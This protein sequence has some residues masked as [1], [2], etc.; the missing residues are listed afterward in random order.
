MIVSSKPEWGVSMPREWNS[1]MLFGNGKKC[2]DPAA[3]SSVWSSTAARNH[4]RSAASR[5][6][7]RKQSKTFREQMQRKHNACNVIVLFC[8]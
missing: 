1:F 4:S 5:A 3:E 6:Q 7:Q 2:D 8:V